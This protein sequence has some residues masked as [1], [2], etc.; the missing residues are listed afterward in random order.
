MDIPFSP[1][2]LQL[3]RTLHL[4]KTKEQIAELLERPVE[5]VVIKIDELNTGKE[6]ELALDSEP[7]VPDTKQRG[8]PDKKKK[9]PQ[10]DSVFDERDIKNHTRDKTIRDM[11]SRRKVEKESLAINKKFKTREVNTADLISVRIDHK[12]IIYVKPGTD[13][14]KVKETYQ[15]KPIGK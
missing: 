7:P 3:I 1:L 2:E 5:A 8:R 13:I 12:T 14:E 11:E 10:A 15:R 6:L 4:S 9:K